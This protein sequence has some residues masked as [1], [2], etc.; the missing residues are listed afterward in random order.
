MLCRKQS[1]YFKKTTI[2]RRIHNGTGAT[3]ANDAKDLN[4]DERIKKFQDQLKNEYV[5]RNI[6]LGKINFPVKID[7]RIKCHLEFE[8]KR[9]FELR[10]VLAFTAAIPS[11]DVKIIF[12]KAP[13]IQYE[14][15]LLDKNFRQYLETIMVSKKILRMGAQKKPIQKTYEINVGQDSLNID[16]LDSNRQF[17]WIELSCNNIRQLQR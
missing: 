17:D 6:Y 7:F 16:F 13:F 2:G 15:L 1:V 9:L 3:K 8:I 10:K 11:P 4:I 12:S 5:Y 14:Q